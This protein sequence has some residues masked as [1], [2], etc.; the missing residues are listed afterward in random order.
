M[1]RRT[2]LTAMTLCIALLMGCATKWIAPEKPTD[3]TAT[4]VP[5]SQREAY[6]L[7]I[8][9]LKSLKF[10][11]DKKVSPNYLASSKREGSIHSISIS[12][13]SVQSWDGLMSIY[14]AEIW[15]ETL[16]E[17]ETQ[18]HV[19]VIEK[20]YRVEKST[21]INESE[22]IRRSTDMEQKIISSLK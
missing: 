3:V 17:N 20:S 4:K 5:H 13:S 12:T 6:Q 11:I 19:Q 22:K 15:L 7:M 8:K 16:S 18:I 9:S 21:L 2:V 14:N 10:K 1:K